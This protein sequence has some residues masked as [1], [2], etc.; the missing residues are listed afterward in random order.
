[1]NVKMQALYLNIGPFC[2]I[3]LYPF[4]A[5]NLVCAKN[6]QIDKSIHNAY[7]K[8]IRSAQH[9]VYIENQYFIGSSYFWSAHR[10]AGNKL[11]VTWITFVFVLALLLTLPI[12]TS[13]PLHLDLL[14]DRVIFVASQFLLWETWLS[15]VRDLWSVIKAI[16]NLILALLSIDRETIELFTTCLIVKRAQIWLVWLQKMMDETS[17]M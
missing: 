10:S 7:V 14:L 1:M 11:V 4:L 9:F 2:E 6:L 17:N 16:N 12:V 15:V 8:A 5:Q 13:F 3:L